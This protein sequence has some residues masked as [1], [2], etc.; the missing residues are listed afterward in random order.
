MTKR[1]LF[2]A[3]M[4]VA[5]GSLCGQKF[6]TFDIKMGVGGLSNTSYSDHHVEF[7]WGMGGNFG[8]KLDDNKLISIGLHFSNNALYNALTL[9]IERDEWGT[10]SVDDS[11]EEW[12]DEEQGNE[13]NLMVD[14]LL[15][16]TT[17]QIPFKIGV[18][19]ENKSTD[20]AFYANAGFAPEILLSRNFH[21]RDY[22]IC[23]KNSVGLAVVADA[24]I[25]IGLWD[26]QYMTLSGFYSRLLTTYKD[27]Y[28]ED[29][30]TRWNAGIVIGGIFMF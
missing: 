24:G 30:F 28:F 15:S 14:G 19:K 2:L 6:A 10:K 27:R 29:K 13:F 12:D 25:A 18:W 7:S 16:L 4:L 5:N 26:N 1:V 9:P 8:F 23:M 22:T 21:Y 3:V 11:E 20:V 17:V